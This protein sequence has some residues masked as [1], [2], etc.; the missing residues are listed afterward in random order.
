MLILLILL[1][2]ILV[3]WEAY[4]TVR[5]CWKAA[6]SGEFKWF[7]FMLVFNLLGLPE[8]YYL[9]GRKRYSNIN[10]IEQQN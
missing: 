5:A 3:A 6:K 2:L 4:W 9:H 10:S 8:I 7:V 1:I